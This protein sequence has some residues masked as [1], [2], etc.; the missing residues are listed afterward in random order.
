[1]QGTLGFSFSCLNP[2]FAKI[3]YLATITAVFSAEEKI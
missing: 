1:M 2:P 3:L